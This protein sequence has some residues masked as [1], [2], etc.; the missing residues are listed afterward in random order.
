VKRTQCLRLAPILVCIV[1]SACTQTVTGLYETDANW[2]DATNALYPLGVDFSFTDIVRT[3]HFGLIVV[4]NNVVL[5]IDDG[6]LNALLGWKTS[7]FW[8]F[9][10]HESVAEFDANTLVFAGA[11][12]DLYVKKHHVEELFREIEH[13]SHVARPNRRHADVALALPVRP[14]HRTG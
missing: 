6:N 14:T 12:P 10:P 7:Y 1:A 4:G 2:V 13:S 3:E 8:A 9:P 5:R 11:M